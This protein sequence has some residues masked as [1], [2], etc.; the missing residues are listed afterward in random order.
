ML[1]TVDFLE[2]LGS[3]SSSSVLD[4]AG[5]EEMIL[6]LDLPRNHAGALLARDARILSNE[7]GGRETMN[8]MI[9]VPD[10]G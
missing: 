8:C 9:L 7:L 3:N 4:V 2:R 5:Y 10:E 1:E 6:S